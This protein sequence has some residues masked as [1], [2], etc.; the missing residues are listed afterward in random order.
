MYKYYLIFRLSKTP[1]YSSTI[2]LLLKLGSVKNFS[3][4]DKFVIVLLFFAKL[5]QQQR[6]LDNLKVYI[7]TKK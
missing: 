5:Q 4:C 2:Q 6:T 1:L 7:H 3:D